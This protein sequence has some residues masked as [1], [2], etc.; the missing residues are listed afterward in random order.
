MNVCMCVHVRYLNRCEENIFAEWEYSFKWWWSKF[1]E[2]CF[3]WEMMMMRWVLWNE[4]PFFRVYNLFQYNKLNLRNYNVNAH[5]FI[6]LLK[7]IITFSHT[8]TQ[9]NY[10]LSI[11]AC[12]KSTYVCIK[13]IYKIVIV[14]R[15]KVEYSEACQNNV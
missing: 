13:F 4:M 12:H 2:G 10:L 15:Q 7:Y 6:V 3:S 11:M 1:F 8:H 5:W 14:S 9:K